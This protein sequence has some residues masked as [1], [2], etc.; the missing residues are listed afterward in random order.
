VHHEPSPNGVPAQSGYRSSVAVSP[1][2]GRDTVPHR[3]DQGDVFSIEAVR[4]ELVFVTEV[5][6][7]AVAGRWP[8]LGHRSVPTSV[9]REVPLNRQQLRTPGVLPC[10]GQGDTQHWAASRFLPGRIPRHGPPETL[11]RLVASSAASVEL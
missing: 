5:C 7:T 8:T 6:S 4:P 10:R 2:Q 11:P 3:S 9:T 1:D